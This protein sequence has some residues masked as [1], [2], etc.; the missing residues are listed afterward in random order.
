MLFVLASVVV[1]G[2][3]MCGIG[4]LFCGTTGITPSNP[5]LYSCAGFFAAG[6]SAMIA[7]F[8][9][10]LNTIA[11]VIFFIVGAAGLPSWWRG[12]RGCVGGRENRSACIIF[13]ASAFLIVFC[14]SCFVSFSEWPYLNSFDNDTD[15]YHANIVQWLNEYGTVP[16]VGNLH[17][18][19]AFNSIWHVLTAILDNSLWNGRTAWIMPVL[20]IIGGAMYFLHELC[21]S[22]KG[23]LCAYSLCSLVCLAILSIYCWPSLGYDAPACVMTLIITLEAYKLFSYSDT[24]HANRYSNHAVI[25]MLAAAAFMI[26]PLA[27]VSLIFAAL[28]VFFPMI[29]NKEC[30]V[31]IWAK[32]WLLP[33]LAG[34]VWVARNLVMSG[35]PLF[36]LPILSF[37]FDWTMTYAYAKINYDA[38][39]AWAKGAGATDF[40]EKASG[41]FWSWFPFWFVSNLSVSP[42][43]SGFQFFMGPFRYYLLCCTPLLLSV[44]VW[45]KILTA[46]RSRVSICFLAFFIGSLIYWLMSAPDIRFASTLFWSEL[47]VALAIVTPSRYK[48][49]NISA[50]WDNSVARRVLSC[51]WV[52]GIAL[53]LCVNLFLSQARLTAH[54]LP[55][56]NVLSVGVMPSRHVEEYTIDTAPPFKVY[57]ATDTP[58]NSPIPA[59]YRDADVLNNL[60]MREPGNIGKG[61][62]PRDRA[63]DRTE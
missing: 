35:Y 48:S 31:K 16:G 30:S 26:K 38:I 51:L 53:G 9:V 7:S 2:L 10:P 58:G 59:A 61:Y 44:P 40:M 3:C 54:N 13:T 6:L 18:R 42:L 45:V 60:E 63:A 43:S 25:L 46:K 62:R 47:G 22:R 50:L 12:Y 5:W 37:D 34:C 56:H 11:L 39:P 19:L 52:A 15:G 14:L 28:L 57:V 36:P 20:L 1:F 24:E 27:A 33:L 41:G 17:A 55:K 49:V 23:S 4:R 21:F 8:F 32:V 29:S